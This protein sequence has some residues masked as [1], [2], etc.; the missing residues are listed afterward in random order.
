MH[1][2]PKEKQ[3]QRQNRETIGESMVLQI[4]HGLGCLLRSRQKTVTGA[5]S[6]DGT[7]VLDLVGNGEPLKARVRIVN[8]AHRWLSLSGKRPVGVGS[9]KGKYK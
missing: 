7:H 2:E 3:E 1:S 8:L 4:A 6:P 5:R 9:T